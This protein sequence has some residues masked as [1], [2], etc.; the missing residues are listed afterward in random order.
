MIK[1]GN[2]GAECAG[3]S[4]FV[5][6]RW[7]RGQ[8]MEGCVSEEKDL[9]LNSLGDG[10]PVALVKEGGDVVMGYVSRVLDVLEFLEVFG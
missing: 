8:V 5:E 3:G 1:A 4:V 2:G 9:Q 6:K 7:Q 10:E